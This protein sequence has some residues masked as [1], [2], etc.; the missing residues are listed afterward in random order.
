MNYF[1]VPND[2]IKSVIYHN[3]E[4]LAIVKVQSVR[5][6]IREGNILKYV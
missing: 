4:K 5:E 2:I 3:K 1:K 6:E